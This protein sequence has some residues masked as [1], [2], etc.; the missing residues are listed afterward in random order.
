MLGPIEM[1]RLAREFGR[2]VAAVRE[3]LHTMTSAEQLKAHRAALTGREMLERAF[4]ARLDDRVDED[5]ERWLAAYLA[6]PTC[7][8]SQSGSASQ[9]PSETTPSHP[10]PQGPRAA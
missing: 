3:R 4:D 5:A 7:P 9:L 6:A 1:G 10:P 8:H 2:A